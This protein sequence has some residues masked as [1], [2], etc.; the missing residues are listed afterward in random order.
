MA[1]KTPNKPNSR[2]SWLPRHI[3]PALWLHSQQHSIVYGFKSSLICVEFDC[4]LK[5]LA[6]STH[7]LWLLLKSS[8]NT[9]KVKIRGQLLHQPPRSTCPTSIIRCIM[10]GAATSNWSQG[11]F[12]FTLCLIFFFDIKNKHVWAF[13]QVSQGLISEALTDRLLST[14]CNEGKGNTGSCAK[15]SRIW[16]V[17]LATRWGLWPRP[18]F[19]H[20]RPSVDG[21]NKEPC[22][23]RLAMPQSLHFEGTLKA[24]CVENT[25]L[26][27]SKFPFTP[28][29]LE[30]NVSHVTKN[31]MDSHLDLHI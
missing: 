18:C 15:S 3:N 26:N 25:I 9:W 1:K 8:E 20:V 19:S 27:K 7:Q 16:L 28:R 31:P 24:S 5:Y 11:C 10:R 29:A 17:V 23:K 6:T 12:Y 30:S 2:L 21:R 14:S 22:L 4:F 13:L